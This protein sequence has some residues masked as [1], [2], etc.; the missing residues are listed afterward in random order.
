[1]RCERRRSAVVFPVRALAREI[2][3]PAHVSAHGARR[4][5]AEEHTYE[6]VDD[7]IRQRVVESDGAREQR[8]ADRAQA[9]AGDVHEETDRYV[10]EFC[11]GERF[12]KMR[13]ID[14]REKKGQQPEADGALENGGEVALHLRAAPLSRKFSSERTATPRR[15]SKYVNTPPPRTSRPS[16]NTFSTPHEG[17]FSLRIASV[18]CDDSARASARLAPRMRLRVRLRPRLSTI[19]ASPSTAFCAPPPRNST[20]GRGTPQPA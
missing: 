11:V 8:P 16:R 2:K 19:D 13:Q 5:Q 9:L 12:D 17:L 6:I 20:G 10:G 14:A 3:H 7:E 15:L 1:D 18:A 4:E